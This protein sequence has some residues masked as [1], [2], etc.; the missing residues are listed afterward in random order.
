MKSIN[1]EYWLTKATLRFPETHR[2]LRLIHFN[3]ANVRSA[4]RLDMRDI[5]YGGALSCAG[6]LRALY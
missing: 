5:S 6:K 3:S 2:P 1:D 4:R